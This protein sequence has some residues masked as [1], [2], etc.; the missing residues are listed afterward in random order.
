MC[1]FIYPSHRPSDL[2]ISRLIY[3]DAVAEVCPDVVPVVVEDLGLAVDVAL[4]VRVAQ[5]PAHLPP[6]LILQLVI[7]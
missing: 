6:T 7:Q 4:A 3:L 2:W 1:T 5:Q